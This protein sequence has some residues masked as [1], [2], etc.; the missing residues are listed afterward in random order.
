MIY[1]LRNQDNEFVKE[2]DTANKKLIFT[3]DPNE[4]IN[5]CTRM[6]G[7]EWNANNEKEFI[8]F[9]FKELGD[10]VSTLSIYTIDNDI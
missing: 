5:Y 2:I 10:K 6:G 1:T 8:Q 4:A 7:G 9:H 3:T